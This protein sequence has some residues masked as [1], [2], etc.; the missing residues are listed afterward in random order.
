MPKWVMDAK[1][2]TDTDG[3]LVRIVFRKSETGEIQINDLRDVDILGLTP[4]EAILVL[5]N[6]KS[7]LV[8]AILMAD[9]HPN[10]DGETIVEMYVDG[11]RAELT[12]FERQV[13][14]D[15]A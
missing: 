9:T 15:N 10:T 8:D 4:D 6:V 1:T 7:L 2:A 3:N 12:E 14:A 5:N 11:W 13:F